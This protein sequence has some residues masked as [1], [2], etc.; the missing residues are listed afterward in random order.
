VELA[1]DLFLDLTCL[2]DLGGVSFDE[3][4]Q[5]MLKAGFEPGPTRALL[6]QANARLKVPLLRPGGVEDGGLLVEESLLFPQ[7]SGWWVGFQQMEARSRSE[8]PPEAVPVVADFLRVLTRSEDVE[9]VREAW[10]FDDPEWLERLTRRG[11]RKGARWPEPDGPGIYRREHASLLICSRTTR[12]LVDPIRLQR[13]L[14]NMERAPTGLG[15]DRVDA[16]AI[17]HGHVDHW[18]VPSLLSQ[19]E[20]PDLPVLVPRVPRPSLLTF[21]DF[22]ATLRAC[23]QNV[24]APGWYETVRVGDIEVDILPFYGEQP[25]REGAV[26]PAGLRNWGN[27][28]RFN[29]EDFSCLVLVDGG[30]DPEGSVVQVAEESYRRRGPVDVVLACQR[31]FFSPFFLGLSHYWAVLPWEQLQ[32]LHK[33]YREQRLRSATAGVEGG[34]EA[35]AAA[36][37]RHFLSYA[38]GFEGVGRP[39]TDVG[40]GD[41]EPSEALCNAR[42]REHLARL[43]AGTEVSEWLPGDVARLEAGQLRVERPGSR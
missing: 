23:G 25:L 28:Y 7:A 33:A 15:A 21:Q 41:G 36:R 11:A 24:L 5:G 26:L 9:Q 27:C 18:H 10:P 35:C 32:E 12:I 29:T 43:K 17:T 14:L 22:E 30:V 8:L 38:N 6:E 31:E 40:W 16:V 1:P 19:L 42:L 34:A 39:I 13:R 4:L 2:P 20:R 3:L 37:A